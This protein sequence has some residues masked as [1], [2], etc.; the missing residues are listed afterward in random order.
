MNQTLARCDA[1]EWSLATRVKRFALILFV[2]SLAVGCATSQHGFSRPAGSI[3][4]FEIKSRSAAFAGTQFGSAGSYERIVAV[5]T[6]QLDPSHPANAGIVDLDKAPRNAAGMVE[7]KTDA[8]ILRPRNAAQARRVLFYDVANRGRPLA[9]MLYFNEGKSFE[10][11]ADAG[12]GFMMRQ[13]YTMVWSGWQGDLPLSANGKVM[14]T[15]FPIARNSD[16]TPIT[17]LVRDEFVF[18]KKGDKRIG[19]LS[20]PVA[21]TDVS[22][23]TLR[24]KGKRADEWV[25]LSGWKYDGSKAIRFDHPSGYD[26]AAIFEFIY[27]ARDPMVKGIG[28]AAVRDFVSFL[29]YAERDNAGNPNP[30]ADLRGARCELESADKCQKNPASTVDVAIMEGISQSGRMVRDFFWQDFNRDGVGRQVFNG[31]MPLIAGSRKTWTNWRFAQPGRWSKQHAEHLQAGDQ[32]PFTYATTTDP[33]S[34]GTDG[35][36]N[37][38]SANGTCPKLMHIDGGA[39]FWQARASLI[40]ADGLG[41][42]IALP[43][44]VRAYLLTGTPH[45]YSVTGKSAKPPICALPSNIVNPA[46]TTRALTVALV[47]W[48]AKGVEP[49]ASRWPSVASGTLVDPGNRMAVRF[50]DLSGIGVQYSGIVN[51]LRV[52]NYDVVPPDVRMN[53]NYQVLVPT[54]DQDGNDVAGVRTPD[55]SVPTGTH[56]S[57]NPRDVGFAPGQLCVGQGSYLPFEKAAQGKGDPRAVLASRYASKADYVSRVKSAAGS[58]VNE[59]LMLTEDVERWTSRASQIQAW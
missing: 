16:G 7:Y 1:Q 58:L 11:V 41:K 29:R 47:D 56:L 34:G 27:P 51:P 59:R 23:A 31:A 28:F 17:G 10:T 33:I 40:G 13:G 4:S 48:I 44:N 32:F 8:M 2:A 36:F 14:G 57:W 9:H 43:G 6:G 24:V 49:P 18:D 19:K 15:Q 39:E 3:Q 38:C 55:I 54:S 45:A 30:L 5:V 46:S 12:T 52:T 50:P 35:V 37:R 22:R 42:D 20:Y 26:A 25:T 53:L 21:D